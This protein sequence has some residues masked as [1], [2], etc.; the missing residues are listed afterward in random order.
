LWDA[1]GIAV[2]P[3]ASTAA[4][5]LTATKLRRRF[6][7]L[8]RSPRQWQQRT[9][10]RTEFDEIIRIVEECCSIPVEESEAQLLL[11][12]LGPR[13]SYVPASGKSKDGFV[14]W[15]L[16]RDRQAVPRSPGVYLFALLN[17]PPTSLP[18][19]LDREVIYVGTTDDQDLR[20]RLQQFEDTALGGQGHSGG[21]SYRVEVY[22]NS[23]ARLARFH[24]TYVS[25]KCIQDGGGLSPSDYECILL[26]RYTSAH[27]RRP[28]LNR[29][30]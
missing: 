30:A 10:T 25:W 12:E 19:P 1:L 4:E 2:Q 13:G 5:L 28:R 9:W 15:Q 23:P 24:K 26:A 6:S 21:W 11:D 27:D 17:S 3:T 20:V 7:E 14:A 16:F 8:T 18:D 22:P 29:K